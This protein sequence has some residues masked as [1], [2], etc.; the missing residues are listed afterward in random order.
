MR[1]N[2]LQLFEAENQ[3]ARVQV[4]A[5]E[6]FSDAQYS[7][8]ILAFRSGAVNNIRPWRICESYYS[9]SRSMKA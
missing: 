3:A 2:R 6:M 9:H 8:P 7:S 5:G 4:T 1:N